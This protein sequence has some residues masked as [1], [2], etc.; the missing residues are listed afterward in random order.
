MYCDGTEWSGSPPVCVEQPSTTAS[1]TLYSSVV[2]TLTSDKGPVIP[3]RP[4]TT[5]F[6]FPFSTPGAPATRQLSRAPVMTTEALVHSTTRRLPPLF[7]T[8]AFLES[9]LARTSTPG[10]PVTAAKTP[11]VSQRQRITG[12]TMTSL[13]A[14]AANMTPQVSYRTTSPLTPTLLTLSMSNIGNATFSQSQD[15]VS[16]TTDFVGFPSASAVESRGVTPGD[17]LQQQSTLDGMNDTLL[18]N[19]TGQVTVLASSAEDQPGGRNLILYAAVVGSCLILLVVG[20]A[21]CRLVRRRAPTFRQ[22]QPMDGDEMQSAA[23]ESESGKSKFYAMQYNELTGTCLND[24]QQ[25]S[26]QQTQQASGNDE[27]SY[28]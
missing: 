10:G 1:V 19:D 6:H 4:F 16:V 2:A 18:A 20:A 8:P 9:T 17:G 21:V 24:E 11:D 22:Y 23:A 15:P 28:L 12:V 13:D 26:L 3:S 25:N 7:S 5:P 27:C 14:A